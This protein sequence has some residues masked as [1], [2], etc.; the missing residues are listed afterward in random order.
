MIISEFPRTRGSASKRLRRKN[1]RM[2]MTQA[3]LRAR[4][5][6]RDSSRNCSQRKRNRRYL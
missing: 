3:L 4:R 5:K 1:R 2:K 6:R